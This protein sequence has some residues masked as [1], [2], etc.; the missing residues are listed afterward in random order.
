MQLLSP[1]VHTIQLGSCFADTA[2]TMHRLNDTWKRIKAQFGWSQGRHKAKRGTRD[3]NMA[4]TKWD[5]AY[6]V[7]PPP[8]RICG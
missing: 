4:P 3:L 8:L 1:A 2:E 6:A 5:Q 7:Q